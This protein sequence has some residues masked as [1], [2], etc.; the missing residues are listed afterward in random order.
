MISARIFGTPAWRTPFE[1]L[2]Q[3][4]NQILRFSNAL[5]KDMN[6][7]CCAGV[8]PLINMTEDTSNYFVSAELPGIKAEDLDISI[9][10]DRLAISGERKITQDVKSTENESL[11]YHR[12]EREVGKFSRMINFP[13]QVDASKT[14]AKMAEGVLTVTLPKTEAA[15]PKRITVH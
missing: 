15:K 10:D 12:R 2:N 3:M 9:T 6:Q 7:E 8:F 1:E 14:E 4:R 13:K 11:K 5:K